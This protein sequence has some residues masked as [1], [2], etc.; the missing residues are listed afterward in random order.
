MYMPRKLPVKISFRSSCCFI[1]VHLARPTC[2]AIV[3]QP[4]IGICLVIVFDDIIWCL[5][6]IWETRIMPIAPKRLGLWPLR[7]EAVP[8]PVVMPTAMPV[9]H[10]V[11]GLCNLI[12]P[13]GLMVLRGLRM[14]IR[15][16]WPNV[17][18]NLG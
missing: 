14:T 18:Q 11:L 5:K 3:F 6:M 12:P 10:T 2:K 1:I 15:M 7:A 4:N 8:F 13:V 16:V 9:M 17:G